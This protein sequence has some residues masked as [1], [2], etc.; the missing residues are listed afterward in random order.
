MGK[1]SEL[2]SE[3]SQGGKLVY[4]VDFFSGRVEQSV[5]ILM[6]RHEDHF[7]EKTGSYPSFFFCKSFE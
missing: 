7:I 2:Y 4:H 6:L 3:V 5:N 1:P